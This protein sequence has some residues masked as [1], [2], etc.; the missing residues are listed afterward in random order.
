MNQH[1]SATLSLTHNSKIAAGTPSRA[2]FLH[3]HFD[4]S[5]RIMEESTAPFPLLP[6]AIQLVSFLGALYPHF[7]IVDDKIIFRTGR[8]QLEQSLHALVSA[9]CVN[10]TLPMTKTPQFQAFD[11]KD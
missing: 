6:S 7:D 3:S 4:N 11:L 5:K 9:L 2:D 1:N 8:P 10:Y